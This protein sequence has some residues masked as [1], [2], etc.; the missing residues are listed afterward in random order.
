MSVVYEWVVE[1]VDS[2]GDIVETAAWDTLSDCRKQMAK[3]NE[4]GCHWELCLVR[5]QGNNDQG[6][7]DRQWAYVVDGELP[8]EFD[9]GAIV[10]KKYLAEFRNDAS[11]T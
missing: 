4:P 7:Q 11:A 6:L 5:N 9:G 3:V 2:D 8:D 10:P 1:E